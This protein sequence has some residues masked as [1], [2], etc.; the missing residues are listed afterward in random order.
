M[1]L[2]YLTIFFSY[3][4]SCRFFSIEPDAKRIFGFAEDMDANSQAVIKSGRFIKHAKFFIQMIDRALGMLGPEE[5]MLTEILLEL[6]AKHV[7]YGVEPEFF[8][9]MGKALIDAVALN[10]GEETFTEEIKADWFEV[11]GAL[12]YDMIRGQRGIQKQS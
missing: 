11:Y 6:G 2:K 7:R 12:S 5:D 8:P 10:L 1:K 3:S 4:F 9:S